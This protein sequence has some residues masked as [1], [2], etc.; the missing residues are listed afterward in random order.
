MYQNMQV[1]SNPNVFDR[2]YNFY[3]HTA[4][5]MGIPMLL[6]VLVLSGIVLVRGGKGT[7]GGSWVDTGIFGAVVLYL[8]VMLIGQVP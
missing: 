3:L 1:G 8:L 7:K 6:L 5:T 2:A 4:A